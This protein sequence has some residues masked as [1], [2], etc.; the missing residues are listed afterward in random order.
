MIPKYLQKI[1]LARLEEANLQEMTN[2][3]SVSVFVFLI[4]SL[5]SGE[6]AGFIGLI[7]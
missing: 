4:L 3:V 7:C 1:N 5:Q 2:N 6:R